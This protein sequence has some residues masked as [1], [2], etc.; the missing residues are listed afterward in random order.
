[1]ILYQHG[2]L[3]DTSFIQILLFHLPSAPIPA[4]LGYFAVSASP[5][6]AG[7]HCLLNHSPLGNTAHQTPPSLCSC[8][9]PNASSSVRFGA[10]YNASQPT[11]PQW[12][13][14][15]VAAL[16]ME[17]F[18]TVIYVFFTLNCIEES[19]TLAVSNLSTFHM[20]CLCSVRR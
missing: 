15:C 19:L 9:G 14:P 8:H 20:L 17:S 3:S 2:R 6:R 16:R 18:K 7:H 1:M 10:G 12:R 11:L 5:V 4:S 13:G